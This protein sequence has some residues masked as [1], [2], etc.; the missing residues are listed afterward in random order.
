M[1]DMPKGVQIS[2]KA[3]EEVREFIDYRQNKG[4]KDRN[5]DIENTIKTG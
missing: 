5:A 1:T 3:F 4:V 2:D